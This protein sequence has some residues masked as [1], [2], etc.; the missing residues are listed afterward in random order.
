MI[1][2]EPLTKMRTYISDIIPRI[3]EFSKKLDN[4]TMLTN[5]HWVVI[6]D[7]DKSKNVYIFRQ[8]NELLISQNGIVEKAKWEYLGHNSL[9]IDRKNESYLFKHGFFDENILALKIDSKEEYAFL[10]NESKY[11]SELNSIDNVLEFLKRKYI[12][13]QIIKS[14]QKKIGA[15]PNDNNTRNEVYHLTPKYKIIKKNE[16]TTLLWGP[17]EII[18]IVYDDGEKGEIY[19]IKNNN[20]AYFKGKPEGYWVILTF[21]Y[22]DLDSCIIALHFFRKN[23]CGLEAGLIGRY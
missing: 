8:N 16:K 7:I 10:V 21:L 12:E 5:Q 18:N 17:T 13:P 15:G 1:K 22:C 20:Q 14:I 3:Q 19:L 6:D 23:K 9:L 4:L 2:H 11:E